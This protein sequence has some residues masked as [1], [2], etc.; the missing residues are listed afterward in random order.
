MFFD[1][2]KSQALSDIY[3][4]SSIGL[5]HLSFVRVALVPIQAK[6]KFRHSASRPRTVTYFLSDIVTR[7]QF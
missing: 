7:T 1:R 6:Q 2:R 5:R 4:R 3:R